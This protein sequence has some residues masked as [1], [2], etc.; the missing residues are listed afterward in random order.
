MYFLFEPEINGKLSF[1]DVD[2]SPQQGKFVTTVYWKPTLNG[3]Y[4]HFDNFLRSVYKVCMI[5]TL[6]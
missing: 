4:T 3:A 6:G 5:Y 1:I 2:V